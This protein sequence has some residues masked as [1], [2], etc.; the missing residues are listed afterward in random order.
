M[1]EVNRKFEWRDGIS[2]KE[3][4]DAR[5]TSV[6][7]AVRVASYALNQRLE[8]M[9]EF[10]AS[11]NDIASRTVPRTEFDLLRERMNSMASCNE[12]DALRAEVKA[13]QQYKATMEGKAS[14][15]SVMWAILLGLAGLLLSAIGL[16][17]HFSMVK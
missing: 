8:G 10:R 7:E 2:L 15:S 1:T 13:L 6:E 14:Q 5:F 17:E 12:L 9:N 3:Y 11:M 4:V 16:I